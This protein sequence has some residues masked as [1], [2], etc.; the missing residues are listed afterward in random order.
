MGHCQQ[1]V[2]GITRSL[3]GQGNCSL[4]QYEENGFCLVETVGMNDMQQA[5]GHLFTTCPLT[6]VHG[7]THSP[8]AHGTYMI[9][10]VKLIG[11]MCID[12]ILY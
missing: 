6:I 3:W 11:H 12:A 9:L 7:H 1:S 8:T 4:L 5:K 2:P 10:H